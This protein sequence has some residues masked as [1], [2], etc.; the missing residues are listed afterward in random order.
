MAVPESK[1][2]VVRGRTGAVLT[3]IAG[4]DGEVFRR[5]NPQDLAVDVLTV[6]ERGVENASRLLALVK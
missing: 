5:Q 2:K 1:D 4:E 6:R 3:G